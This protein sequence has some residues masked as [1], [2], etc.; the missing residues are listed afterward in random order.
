MRFILLV[1]LMALP[2]ILALPSPNDFGGL[3]TSLFS[4][5]TSFLNSREPRPI[6]PLSENEHELSAPTQRGVEVEALSA[7]RYKTSSSYPKCN[8]G[9]KRNGYA[10]YPGWKIVGDD[11]SGALPVVPRP[12]CIKVCDGYGDACSGTYFDDAS[13]KCF[14]KG[15]KV[16]KWQFVETDQEGDSV[17]LIGGC[18]AWSEVVPAEMDETC[19][20][21]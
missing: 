18:A 9:G 7:K 3:S 1:F 6:S 20:R 15:N 17:D 10:H 2:A 12:N 4:R 5:F 16:Q 19:C 13:N 14:L 11:L 8:K 21:D